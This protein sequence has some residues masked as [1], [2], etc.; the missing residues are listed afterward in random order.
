MIKQTNALTEKKEDMVVD[1]IGS[2]SGCDGGGGVTPRNPRSAAVP[3]PAMRSGLCPR[4]AGPSYPGWS[5]TPLIV[6]IRGTANQSYIIEIKT[7]S[8]FALRNNIALKKNYF[9]T[10]Q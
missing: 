8:P 7:T 5:Q 2:D 4:Y 6:I 3:C 9:S 10:L 1:Q